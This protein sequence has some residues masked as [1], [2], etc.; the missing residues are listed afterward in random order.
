M[1]LLRIAQQ[2]NI[3]PYLGVIVQFFLLHSASIIMERQYGISPI[4]LYLIVDYDTAGESRFRTVHYP[5]ANRTTGVANISANIPRKLFNKPMF[6][7]AKPERD[8]VDSWIKTIKS[9]VRQE[10]SIIRRNT[11][12]F[13]SNDTIDNNLDQLEAII[14]NTYSRAQC[15]SDFNAFFL[16]HVVNKTWGF[17][18][19]F[20]RESEIRTQPHPILNKKFISDLKY[21]ER[22]AFSEIAQLGINLKHKIHAQRFPMWY[23]CDSCLERLPITFSKNHPHTMVAICPVC[24]SE[25]IFDLKDLHSKQA[26]TTLRSG[27]MAR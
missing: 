27:N 18:T 8:K 13:G 6:A 14:W 17:P 20:V 21:S 15:L 12:W 1:P 2:P 10:T 3:F 7:L 25:Y 19:L 5:D 24:E 16:S 9:V 23:F 11:S 4:E 22:Q 26:L